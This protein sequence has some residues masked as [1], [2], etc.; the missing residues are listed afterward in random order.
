MSSLEHDNSFCFSLLC[1]LVNII[2]IFF[3]FFVME[4]YSNKCHS[5]TKQKS[6][7]NNYSK[8]HETKKRHT[9]KNSKTKIKKDLLCVQ[10]K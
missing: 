8:N 5:P 9:N 4:N 7:S 2:E 1:L 6:H 3:T 10:T